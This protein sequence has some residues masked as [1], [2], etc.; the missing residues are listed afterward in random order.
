MFPER[1]ELVGLTLE[2][3]GARV[4]VA[5]DS[6]GHAASGSREVRCQSR[7]I[8]GT[9][10]AGGVHEQE[11]RDRRRA[12]WDCRRIPETD[13]RLIRTTYSKARLGE[14]VPCNG[15]RGADSPVGVSG[16]RH[17]GGVVDGGALLELGDGARKSDSG[18][19]RK[20]EEEA[21]HVR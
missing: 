16:G 12:R 19:G 1:I 11:G 13:S 6:E 3:V 17:E 14:N 2:E 7:H 21:A 10:V 15:L 8:V 5:G 4:D 18:E 9:S 20:S